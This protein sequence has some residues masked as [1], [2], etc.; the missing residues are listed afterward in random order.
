MSVVDWDF[1]D[2]MCF[3][4]DKNFFKMTEDIFLLCVY[5]RSNASTREDVSDGLNCY[6]VLCDQIASVSEHGGVIVVG[7]FNARSG[8][9]NEC[10]LDGTNESENDEVHGFVNTYYL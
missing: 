5:M 6:D 3:K 8:V 10:L 9:R 7:D 4:L 2:G 1:E